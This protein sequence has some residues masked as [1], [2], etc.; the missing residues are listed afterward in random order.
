MY[1]LRLSILLLVAVVLLLSWLVI[2]RLFNRGEAN[3]T[4]ASSPL[5]IPTTAASA[6]TV[7]PTSPLATVESLAVVELP[8]PTPTT[9]P[10]AIARLEVAATDQSRPL[11]LII[12]SNPMDRASVESAFHVDPPIS[13]LLTWE[14]DVLVVQP[15]EPLLPATVINLYM[16]RS[17]TTIYGTPLLDTYQ[18]QHN[19]PPPILA[20]QPANSFDVPPIT[21][22]SLT[23]DRAMDRVT[24]EAALTITPPI[25]GTMGWDGNTL[26]ITPT[27]GYLQPETRYTW[28]L[29]TTATDAAGNR[30]LGQPLYHEFWTTALPDLGNFGY[31]PNA[32]VVLAE[33]NRSIQYQAATVP[34]PHHFALYRFTPAQFVAR[35][36]ADFVT[37]NDRRDRIISRED[38]ELVG[39]WQDTPVAIEG[40][41]QTQSMNGGIAAVFVTQIP[42]EIPPGLYMLEM[43]IGPS[44]VTE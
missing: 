22:F 15:S 17:A 34:L 8:T 32:Q 21:P 18:W 30:V 12:F 13:T 25:T 36:R 31:G 9:P 14:D 28:S 5:R 26:I 1:R 38:A 11:F 6:I 43:T 33:G 4:A 39:N 20:I 23:F 35:Y 44:R 7:Q 40:T 2:P 42:P 3:S 24:T 29:E 41:Q 37:G 16:E 27:S 10:L 19:V